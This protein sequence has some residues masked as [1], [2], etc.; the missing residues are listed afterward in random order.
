[1]QHLKNLLQVFE[2]LSQIMVKHEGKARSSVRSAPQADSQER[3]TENFNHTVFTVLAT[4]DEFKETYTESEANNMH[5][6]QPRNRK[7]SKS[8]KHRGSGH[9]EYE[10]SDPE[11]L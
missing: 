4:Q 10:E 5:E 7:K 3:E 11:R 8:S 6:T 9:K 2:Y 1:M